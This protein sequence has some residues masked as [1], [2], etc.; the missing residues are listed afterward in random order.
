MALSPKTIVNVI[1][2]IKTIIPDSPNLRR[3]N[4]LAAVRDLATYYADALKQ[5]QAEVRRLRKENTNLANE[6][7]RL[8]D[9]LEQVKR[10]GVPTTPATPEAPETTGDETENSDEDADDEDG[11]ESDDEE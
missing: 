10:N 4:V 2:F 8:S 9:E 5:A 1:R 11:D 7:M 6:V 3:G